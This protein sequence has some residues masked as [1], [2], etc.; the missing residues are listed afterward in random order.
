MA[1]EYR[2]WQIGRPNTTEEPAGVWWVNGQIRHIATGEL[3]PVALPDNF[4]T[5][6]D[7]QRAYLSAA[8]ARIASKS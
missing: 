6:E 4:G 3:E 1:I 7:A 8:R 2:G 5:R